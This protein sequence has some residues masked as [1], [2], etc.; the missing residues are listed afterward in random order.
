MERMAGNR[1]LLASYLSFSSHPRT[2]CACS[3]SIDCGEI[4]EVRKKSA[5][6][7]KKSHAKKFKRMLATR[8]IGME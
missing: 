4:A 7:F 1:S 2:K 5:W 3:P 6:I 8:V